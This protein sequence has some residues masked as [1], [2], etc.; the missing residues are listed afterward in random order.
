MR[1]M[2]YL[3]SRSKVRC[4]LLALA[5]VPALL[6]CHQDMWNQPRYAPLQRTDF[7]SDLQ[8][9]RQPVPGTVAYDGVRRHWT[10]P[11]FGELS[12]EASVPVRTDARFWNAKEEDGTFVADG[13]FP[14]TMALLERGRERFNINCL[15]CHGMVGDGKGIISQRGFP[16]PA[17]F[18]TDRLREV[19]DG[20]IFDVITRGFGRMYSYAARVAPEDRWAIAAYLR[21]LQT[22]QNLDITGDSPLA[23][24]VQQAVANQDQVLTQQHESAGHDGN[25]DNNA[26]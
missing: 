14:V 21:A 6:G 20:Y 11:V 17:S 13:Y 18:H 9:S 7:F 22:S 3:K 8:A 2:N 4:M 23:L 25:A 26:H 24:E 16:H 12:G 1:L 10:A 5:S 15:P 19:E